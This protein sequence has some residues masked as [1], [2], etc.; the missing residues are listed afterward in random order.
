[1]DQQV[2]TESRVL[3]ELRLAAFLNDEKPDFSAEARRR[4]A[5][6]LVER[7]LIEREMELT[8]FP[9]SPEDAAKL[10]EQMRRGRP[11]AEYRAKLEAYEI[12][13]ESL[14]QYLLR[15]AALLRFLEVRFRPEAQVSEQEVRDCLQK[16][17]PKSAASVEEAR[18]HCE[19]ALVAAGVDKALDRWLGE[20]RERARIVYREGAFR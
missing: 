3:E 13:E 16:R 7:L 20:V 12:T 17:D 11:E 14:Q 8:R 4:A 9:S 1:V 18:A 15:Q 19:E 10:L 2:I 5:A 6:R